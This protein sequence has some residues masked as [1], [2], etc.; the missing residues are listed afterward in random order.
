MEDDLTTAE[1]Y[2]ALRAIDRNIKDL[3]AQRA[4]LLAQL[5]PL[6][7]TSYMLDD[8]TKVVAELRTSKRRVVNLFKLAQM[9]PVLY[10]RITE[11]KL[12]TEALDLSLE[13]GLWNAELLELITES[14]TKPWIAFT[15]YFNTEESS[16]ED[17]REDDQ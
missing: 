5:V 16:A 13:A 17:G 4:D 10:R 1:A 12:N 8:D 15:E 14:P 6:G 2:E 7:N 11:R 9:N 3:Q